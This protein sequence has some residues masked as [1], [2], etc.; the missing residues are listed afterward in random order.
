MSCSK[1]KAANK[2][3]L[4]DTSIYSSQNFSEKILDS[5]ILANFYQK[6]HT[7]DSLQTQIMEFYKRRNY[8]YAWF[9]KNG[10]TEASHIFY[11]QLQSFSSDFD[12]QSINTKLIDSLINIAHNEDK[13]VILPE[14]ETHKIEFLLTSNFFKYAEKAFGGIAKNTFDLEWFVPRK[15]KNFQILLDNI[16]SNSKS[17][18]LQYSINQ[19][20]TTLTSQLRNYKSIE[21]SGGFPKIVTLKKQIIMGESDTCLVALK[22]YLLMTGDIKTKDS[23]LIFDENL[24][25]AL[26][27][28]QNRHGLTESGILNKATIAELNIPIHDRI[29]QMM[30]NLERLRW[31]PEEMEPNFLLVN[32]PEFKLHIFENGKPISQSKVV[33]GKMATQTSIFKGQLSTVVLNPYWGLP[34]SIVINEVLPKIKRNVSYLSKNNIEVFSKNSIIDPRNVNWNQYKTQV[35][36]NFRQKPGKNNS[37]GKIK[38]LF[39]NNYNIYLHDTPAKSLFGETNRSFSHGCI[40]VENPKSLAE[41]I[42]RNDAKWNSENIDNILK[43]DVE[44]RITVTPTLPVYLLY[45]TSWVAHDG[46]L[47]FRKDIYGHDKKLAFEIFAKEK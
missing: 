33:V 11:N 15:K 35:P 13:K 46:N 2:G 18:N 34:N 17:K 23:T 27:N 45:L 25:T 1:N 43:T 21:K 22:A 10:I 30:V 5:T 24:K 20:Y 37:L 40:R 16:I 42:L 7:D 29:S 44:K 12:D 41:Y 47:H 28:F 19:Y 39:P 38:F 3:I 8:Q 31:L 32:I 36:Y 9:D 26:K 14:S 4:P 6:Y